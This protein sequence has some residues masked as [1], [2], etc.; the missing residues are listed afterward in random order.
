MKHNSIFFG[1]DAF[2]VLVLDELV[3]HDIPPTQIITAPDR[4]QGRGLHM[5]PPAVKV[6]A[7]EHNI[8]VLQ[9]EKLSPEFA[10]ALGDEW[11][12]FLLASYGGIIPQYILDIPKKGTLNVHPSLLPKYRGA[13][14]IET[15]ILNDDKETGVTIMLMDHKVDHGPI[16]MQEVVYFNEWPQKPVVRD[17]L[18][19]LG[20]RLLAEAIPLW[21]SDSIDAQEQEHAHATLTQ[22]IIKTDGAL[23]LQEDAYQ[24]FLKIQ[25]YT[26]WPGTH[27]FADK[28]DVSVRVK[29]TA[30]V[31][32]DSQLKILR[33]IPEGKKEMD[34]ASFLK[35][36][37]IQ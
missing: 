13:S 7:D 19:T 1:T 26:P 6:W 8:P 21:L 14:P 31:Y 12:I 25:A 18:A 27:F 5:T 4:P 2:S 33:V 10:A 9:P 20:G 28:Q 17:T 15:A 24:N 3:R 35:H 37:T 34:Y 23:N 11:D 30:A 29:I 16:V 22:K 32:E 36:Y